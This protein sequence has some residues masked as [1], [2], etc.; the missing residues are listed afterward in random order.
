MQLDKHL[1]VLNKLAA[2]IEV[3]RGCGSCICDLRE[4]KVDRAA[5]SLQWIHICHATPIG[6]LN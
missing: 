2:L 4:V 5:Y 1:F 3:L 6:Y